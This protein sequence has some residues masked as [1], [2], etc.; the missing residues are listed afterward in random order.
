MDHPEFQCGNCGAAL[1]R[2]LKHARLI[3]CTHCGS[4]SVLKDEAFELAGNGGVV[5]DVPSLIQLDREVIAATKALMPVG[6]AQFSYGRGLWDE[7]WCLDEYGEGWWL[8]S[9]EGDYALE[10]PV[11]KKN[12]PRSFRPAL[13]AHC[14]INGIE[15]KVTETENATCTAV[16]GEFPELLHIGETHLYFDLSGRNAEIATYEKWDGGEGWSAGRWIDPWD[17]S[18]S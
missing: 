8:S 17:V 3:G 2:R 12:W 13:G 9:D 11:P 4:T 5:Q 6:H 18:V 1:P 7:Y 15:Y 14:Q 16:R 10:R